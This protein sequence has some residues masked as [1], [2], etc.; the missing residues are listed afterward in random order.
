MPN[1]LPYEP[2]ALVDFQGIEGKHRPILGALTLHVLP[3]SSTYCAFLNTE[4]QVRVAK[5]LPL[6]KLVKAQL[7]V[8]QTDSAKPQQTKKSPAAKKAT[9][10]P[11]STYSADN[12]LYHTGQSGRKVA[13]SVTAEQYQQYFDAQKPPKASPPVPPPSKRNDDSV[14]DIF[15]KNPSRIRKASQAHLTPDSDETI[16]AS[17]EA[18]DELVT[19]TLAKLHLRQGNKKEAIHIYQKLSLLFPEKSSYFEAQIENTRN[20]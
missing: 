16:K 12:L 5:L 18:D 10:T 4:I 17:V 8:S 13:I 15:L 1:N 2:F 7:N 20:Q 19:E 6:V 11:Q 9:P 14:F 3:Y